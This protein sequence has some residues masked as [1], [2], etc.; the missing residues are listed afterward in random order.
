M[1]FSYYFEKFLPY[2]KKYMAKLILKHYERIIYNYLQPLIPIEDSQFQ[3]YIFIDD[4]IRQPEIL[5]ETLYEFQTEFMDN[6]EIHSSKERK[7]MRKHMTLRCIYKDPQL[8]FDFIVKLYE[9]LRN[10]YECDSELL[11][12]KFDDFE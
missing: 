9:T 3:K 2:Y 5:I 1:G 7:K 12:N 6:I 10:K 11:E 8:L 4:I